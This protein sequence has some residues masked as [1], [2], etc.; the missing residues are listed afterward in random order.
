MDDAVLA[1]L[2]SELGVEPVPVD[3]WLAVRLP[4]ERRGGVVMQLRTTERG[5][6]CRAFVM[7]CPDRRREAVYRRLLRKNLDASDWRWAV[8]EAGDVF[9]TAYV[10]PPDAPNVLDALLGGACAAVDAVY[11]G[12]VRT[13]FDIPEGVSLMPPSDEG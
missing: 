9:L 12:I 6:R 1:S 4:S 8:D 3:G 10:A 13:G 5:L 2:L 11:E 7:R